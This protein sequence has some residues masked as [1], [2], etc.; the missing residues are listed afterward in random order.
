MISARWARS[1][2]RPG[3]GLD[4][5]WDAAKSSVIDGVRELLCEMDGG[6]KTGEVLN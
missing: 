3:A 6:Q 2:A 1:H 5:G 4:I